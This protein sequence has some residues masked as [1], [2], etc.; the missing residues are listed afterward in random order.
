MSLLSTPAEV[1]QF[2]R[3][4]KELGK[5]VG[6]VP[7]MGYLHEGHGSLFRKAAATSDCV[8]ASCFVN[9]TQFGE[10]D[11]YVN[12]PKD[13]LRDTQLAE[14][15][16]VDALFLPESSV[17]Y[18]NGEQVTVKVNEK[19]DVLCGKSRPGHFDGVATVL[20]KLFTITQPDRVYFGMKDAQQVAIVSSLIE[21]FHFPIELIACP[22]V[23]EEDGLAK[24]S[25]N[26]RLVS[27]ER[28]EAPEVYKGLQFGSELILN[29][30]KDFDRIIRAVR[31]YYKKHLTLGSVDY[32]DVLNYPELTRTKETM[33]GRVIIACAVRYLN[34]RLI[35]NITINCDNGESEASV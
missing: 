20:T 3:E 24:S 19:N 16:G 33:S 14:S 32:I 11:D 29:G 27:E 10:K 15:C 7:T 1:R 13:R 23:R 6:F 22:I 4:Q 18:P 21:S 34:A 35:D 8:I 30:E 12:Y 5:T 9:P 25:R 2:V 28:R 31:G 17:I 26:V